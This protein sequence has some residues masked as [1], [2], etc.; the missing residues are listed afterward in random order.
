MSDESA[1]VLGP[2][3]L[4]DLAAK[5]K[6]YKLLGLLGSGG[7]AELFL[8]RDE[9]PG[10]SGKLL[11]IKRIV[12]AL[13]GDAQSVLMFL[14]EA[15]IASTLQHSNIVQAY[16]VDVLDGE[17]FLAMEFLHGRDATAVLRRTRSRG[18]RIPLENAVAVAVGVAA[19]LQYAHENEG[20]TVG[21]SRSSTVMS[22]PTT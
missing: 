8:A 5:L 12:P 2:R 20:P 1:G 15:R 19:G 18:L 14:D 11:V 16:D 9:S 17:L 10:G 4:R 22:R 13:A 6:K 21:R 3:A 7:M